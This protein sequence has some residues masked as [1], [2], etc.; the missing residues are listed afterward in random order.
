LKSRLPRFVPAAAAALAVAF[1]AAPAAA[2]EP[3]DL[4]R[5][6]G[7]TSSATGNALGQGSC[8]LNGD[9]Y[10]DAVVG[11]WF[12]DKAPNNNVGA[13]YVLFGGPQVNGG[14]LNVPADAGAARIDGPASAGAFVGFSVACAGDVNGD[15]IDDMALSYYTQEKAYVVL[16][17]EEFGSVD[18]SALGERGFEVKGDLAFAYNVGNNVAGAGD[19]NGDGLDD[20]AV[21]GVVADTLGR[22]NNGR[23]WI[24]A[25]KEDVADVEL[26]DP[27]TGEAPADGEILAV[28]D[29]ARSEG[30]LGQGG[31]SPAGDVNADGTDD[32]VMG[33]YADTPWGAG[34]AVPGA[35]WVLWGDEA[36]GDGDAPAAVDLNAIGSAG[37]E[38]FGPKR[39]RDRLGVSVSGAG[40]LNGDGHDDV[41]LGGDGVYN[42]ATGQRPG[43]AWV[44]FGADSS[45]RVYTETDPGATAAVYTCAPDAG[46]GTCLPEETTARGYWIKGADSDPGNGSESTGYSLAGIGDVS[47]D[48]I[49]DLAIGA[50]GYD[51][52]N[53]ASP[54]ATMAGSGAVWIVHG[55]ADTATQDLAALTEADGHRIDGLAAG[56][57]FGRAVAALGDVD[58]NGHDDFAG[59]GDFAQRPLPPGTPRTQAGEVV[60]ALLGPPTTA[61]ELS[62]SA[63]G[64][65]QPGQSFQLEASVSATRTGATPTDGSV[66]FSNAGEPLPA[67]EALPLVAGEAACTASLT[68]PGAHQLVAEYGGSA[69]FGE[70]VSSPLEHVVSAPPGGPPR[71]ATYSIERTAKRAR[72]GRSKRVKLPLA[73]RC[74]VPAGCSVA[75]SDPR[76]RAGGREL[77]VKVVGPQ[78]IAPGATP[79][80]RAKLSGAAL[81]ALREA[82]R[83]RLAVTVKLSDGV[84]ALTRRVALTLKSG[85]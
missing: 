50:Y 82:G 74:G 26:I 18:L 4:L 28:I 46:T 80:V 33:A 62:S 76:L 39:Q 32:F 8:D 61:V 44:V 23:I 66:T 19:V 60:I 24:V 42:A 48:S 58:G 5:Y 65:L 68:A 11:A 47:G 71:A 1:G 64:T 67:C 22:T 78:R 15:G 57:R 36:W 73:L 69:E 13:A 83:G 56:D 75:F 9:G 12:W 38:V 59:A 53:P 81:R 20:I 49:P 51:P 79:V 34:V 30:R 72:V 6:Y 85:R 55:K 70:S 52:V 27:G 14:D 3:T 7:D 84:T 37:F 16:G 63:T 2:A 41:V 25:G 35:A 77:A 54:A 40:D 10:D 31:L 29:G 45:A 21:A 17:A 43:S